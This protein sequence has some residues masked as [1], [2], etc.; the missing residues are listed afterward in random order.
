[1]I[2]FT[3]NKKNKKYQVARL[4]IQPD[5]NLNELPSITNDL[6]YIR[7]LFNHFI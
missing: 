4:V 3:E 7:W 5:T 1:M 2:C 6:Y